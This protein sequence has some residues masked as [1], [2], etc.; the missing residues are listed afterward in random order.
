MGVEE[1][2]GDRSHLHLPDGNVDGRLDQ[3][4]LHHKL[5]AV[6][7]CHPENR[8]GVAVQHLG[9]VLLPPV[10]FHVLVKVTFGVHEPDG[11]HRHAEIARC[12]DVVAREDSEPAR[13]ERERVVQP[14][15][16]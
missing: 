10:R 8:C 14:E 1:E 5:P 12:F 6:V 11:N 9:D 4:D 15:L 2:E 7:A 13:V 16:A 3:G